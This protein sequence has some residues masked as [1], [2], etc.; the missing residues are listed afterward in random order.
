MKNPSKK[1]L[2]VLN[3]ISNYQ[4]KNRMSPTNREICEGM[5]FRSTSTVHDYLIRMARN[6]LVDADS[7]SIHRGLQIR[8]QQQPPNDF[9][10]IPVVGDIAAGSPIT[11]VENIEGYLP[12]PYEFSKNSDMFILNVKGESMINAGIMDK[13]QI[14][15][16]KQETAENGDIVVALIGDEATVKRFYRDEKNKSYILKP[17]NDNMSPIL[18][19]NVNIIGRVTG[20]FRMNI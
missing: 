18:L 13:D 2:A 16:T 8:A 19:K 9:R 7:I 14:I 1:Q 11:A 3:F 4:K 10:L 6:G 17:E 15:V 20:L 12:L 5:G